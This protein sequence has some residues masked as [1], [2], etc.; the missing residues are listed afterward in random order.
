LIRR[1][2]LREVFVVAKHDGGT[3]PVGQPLQRAPHLVAK[4]GVMFTLDGRLG[5]L[6]G[7]PRALQ[8][9]PA[10]LRGEQIHDGAPQVRIEPVGHP[11]VA[12]AP[13][14]ANER[15]L[16]Q[17]L[18]ELAVS[19]EEVGQPKGA[20]SVAHVRLFEASERRPCVG[21]CFFYQGRCRVDRS[22]FLHFSS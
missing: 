13:G 22:Q 15:F 4:R 5:R 21:G 6:A 20:G 12:H 8:L 9:P 11:E 18:G 16:H 2:S 10:H 7:E 19:R 17:V 1:I 14:D 3:L